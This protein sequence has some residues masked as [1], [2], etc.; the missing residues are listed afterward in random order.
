GIAPCIARQAVGWVVRRWYTDPMDPQQ[1]VPPTPAATQYKGLVTTL[2]VI[3]NLAFFLFLGLFLAALFR[4]GPSG[5]EYVRPTDTTPWLLLPIFGV[6]VV[7]LGS[8]IIYQF[9]SRKSAETYFGPVIILNVVQFL[10]SIAII[11]FIVNA[12]TCT[13]P[14]LFG[15]MIC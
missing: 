6:S 7:F 5:I 14:H 3:I 8:S 10:I 13:W 12:L 2:S 9:I 4:L 1:P 11:V 15:L